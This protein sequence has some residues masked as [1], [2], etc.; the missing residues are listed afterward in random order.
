MYWGY[1]GD[2]GKENGNCYSILASAFGVKGSGFR[3]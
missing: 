1:I 3:A 2:D